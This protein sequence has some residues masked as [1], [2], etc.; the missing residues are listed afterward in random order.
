VAAV[1]V[2]LAISTTHLTKTALLVVV[3]SAKVSQG[4]AAANTGNTADDYGEGDNQQHTMYD[5]VV[6]HFLVCI[7]ALLFNK[8]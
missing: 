6:E 4:I 1:V 8:Y 7:W 2:S 3:A 5:F